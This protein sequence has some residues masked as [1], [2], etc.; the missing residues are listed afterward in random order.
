MKK[1]LTLPSRAPDTGRRFALSDHPLLFSG[2]K[3]SRLLAAAI[4]C[5]TGMGFAY[6]AVATA[7]DRRNFPPPG[8]LLD[9]GGSRLH[10]RSM[11]MG[12]PAVVLETGLGGMSAAWGW[13]QPEV[14]KFT[15]V[16]AYDRGGLGW[17]EPGRA[18]ITGLH[19]ARQLRRLLHSAGV[20]GPYVLVGHSMGGLYLRVFAHEYHEEVAGMVLV[21]AAHPNQYWRSSA[22]RDHMTSGFR[23][24]K[25]IPLLARLGYVRMSRFFNSWAEGLPARQAAEAKAFLC[26]HHHL[27]TTRDESLAWEAICSEVRR[28]AG[29]GNKPLA[30]VSAGQ[31]ILAGGRELQQELAGLS[32]NSIHIAVD[33]ADHV[34][35]VTHKAHAQ[36]VVD[37][38]RHVIR[39]NPL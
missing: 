20:D 30:V 33:D 15:R 36:L 37:A 26:S 7:L 35:L 31:D 10:I 38:I 12:H 1:A 9:V 23:M 21:D 39:K 18:P 28:T 2:I 4:P 5:L 25:N 8:N 29:L 3:P 19:V 13:I 34:T 27:K 14:A 32:S 11:G 17:S 22:I 24:L 6:Q 16:V